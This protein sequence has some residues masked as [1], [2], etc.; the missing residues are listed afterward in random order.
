MPQ[1]LTALARYT[2]MSRRHLTRL[3]VAETRG[4]WANPTTATYC[5]LVLAAGVGIPLGRLVVARR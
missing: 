5:K 2:G 1:N 3:R 4:D